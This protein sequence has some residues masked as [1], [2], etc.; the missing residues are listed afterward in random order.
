VKGGDHLRDQGID[1]MMIYILK[2]SAVKMWI[3]NLDV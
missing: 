2:P 3:G 1:G